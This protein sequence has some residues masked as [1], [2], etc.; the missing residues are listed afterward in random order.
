MN[1][2]FFQ[3]YGFRLES[4]ACSG[5]TGKAGDEADEFLIVVWWLGTTKTPYST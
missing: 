2:S 4:V 5:F 3:E 1:E